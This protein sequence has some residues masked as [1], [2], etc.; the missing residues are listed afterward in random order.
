M[1]EQ[2][3][4]RP[5]GRPCTMPKIKRVAKNGVQTSPLLPDNYMELVY[6]NPF[7]FKKTLMI[8]KTM[9]AKEIMFDFGCEEIKVIAIDHLRQSNILLTI[10]C[11][12]AVR[13][14]C[15][16]PVLSIIDAKKFDKIMSIINKSYTTITI[17]KKTNEERS[18]IIFTLTDVNEMDEVYTVDLITTQA[19]DYDDDAFD[20]DEHKISFMMTDKLFKSFICNSKI[21]ANVLTI[22]KYSH[23]HPLTVSYKS[24]DKMITGQRVIKNGDKINLRCDNLGENEIFSM[25]VNI[26]FLKPITTAIPQSSKE[27]TNIFVS[28][29]ETKK[30]VVSY[31]VDNGFM[32][33]A[34]ATTVLTET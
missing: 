17:S 7:L 3:Q 6:D 25:S 14:F 16:S 8:F 28:L 23:A 4:K 32:N 33:V 27:G 29:H 13:Y 21:M 20:V 18:R 30:M 11:S 24:D 2:D 10:D 22:R 19:N 9:N 31:F 15:R 12:K 34:V 26:G 5:P 1:S